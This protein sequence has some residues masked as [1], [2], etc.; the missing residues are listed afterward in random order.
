MAALAAWVVC[1]GAAVSVVAWGVAVFGA[2]VAADLAAADRRGGGSHGPAKTGQAFAEHALAHAA[3]ISGC[4]ANT[5]A[6]WF[7]EEELDVAA[8]LNKTYYKFK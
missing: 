6:G 2:G 4:N 7:P 5:G 1:I 8:H 3:R